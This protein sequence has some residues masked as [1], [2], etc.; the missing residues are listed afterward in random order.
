VSWPPRAQDFW[1]PTITYVRG[2]DVRLTTWLLLLATCAWGAEIPPCPTTSTMNINR[3]R[4]AAR[5]GVEFTI[6]NYAAHMVPRGKTSP[7]CYIK[8]NEIEHG[9]IVVSD[10]A[11]TKLFE[12]KLA[13]SGKITGL[14]VQ[15]KDGHIMLSGTAHKGLPI[16]FTVEGPV[17][18]VDGREIRLHAEKVKAV[19]LP[20]KGLLEM[21]GVE[22]GSLL[23]PGSNKGVMVKESD[24]LFDPT[25]L[26]NIR[27]YI[28]HVQVSGQDLVVDFGKPPATLAQ[29][30]VSKRGK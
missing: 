10:A 3:G 9:H 30:K 2:A 14:K 18:T 8:I 21:V 5:P 22:L 16:P 26:G 25:A 20:V 4:Y 17:D 6:E 27:G 15:A 28:E 23:N 29:A 13:H 19:G 7:L 11:L 24:I 12:Q 1:R